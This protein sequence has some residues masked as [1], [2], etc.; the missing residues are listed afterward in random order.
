M[1]RAGWTG[2]LF[3]GLAAFA[4]TGCA[5]TAADW[6][7]RYLEKEQEAADLSTNLADERNQRADAVAQLE[8]ARAR[9]LEL[10]KE[11]E[12]LRNRPATVAE[13]PVPDSGVGETLD[14]LKKNGM[15]AYQT[16]DGNIAIVLP[17]DITFGAGSKDL[18]AA[19]KKSVDAVARELQSTFAG[20]T[21]RVEGH[22]D[23]DPIRK[24]K[25]TDNWELGG[26]RAL[27]VLRYLAQN[28][29]VSPERLMGATRGETMPVADNKSDKGKARN[30]RVEIVVIV[31]RDQALAR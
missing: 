7:E 14:R 17:S 20:Q 28:H 10:E 4:A 3:L 21:V 13:A 1:A 19:G 30:R 18:T 16:A 24:S 5:S 23:G 9:A 15:D 25:F 29:S 2:V 6:R 22:T 12:N 31:P 8:E 26:E 27:T 11:N